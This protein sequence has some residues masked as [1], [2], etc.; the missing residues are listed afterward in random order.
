MRCSSDTAPAEIEN[1]VA[2]SETEGA[3]AERRRRVVA[4]E[5]NAGAFAKLLCC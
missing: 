1:S 3:E 2:L 4:P 5:E